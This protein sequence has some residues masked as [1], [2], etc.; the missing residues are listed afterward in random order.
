MTRALPPIPHPDHLRRPARALLRAWRAGDAEALARA[1]REVWFATY[2][3]HDDPAATAMAVAG[4]AWGS[5]LSAT[6]RQSKVPIGP[7]NV[8]SKNTTKGTSRP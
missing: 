8:S 2:I 7:T 6:A 5:S 3:F 4:I 1:H